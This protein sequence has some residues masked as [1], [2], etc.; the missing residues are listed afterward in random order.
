MSDSAFVAHVLDLLR[1]LGGVVARRMFGAYGLFRRGVMFALIDDDVL[2]LRST[3][4]RGRISRPPAR[5]RS[6]MRAAE[7]P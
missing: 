5:R 6:R 3:T 2:Y 1:P 4:A 7:R